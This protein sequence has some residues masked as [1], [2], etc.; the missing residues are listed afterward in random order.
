[1]DLSILLT[2]V[3]LL[4]FAYIVHLERQ[5]FSERK[6][7]YDRIMGVYVPYVNQKA[8]PKGK[9][10]IHKSVDPDFEQRLKQDGLYK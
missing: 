2:V 10:P 7:L 6:D 4:Q 8:A 1:M 3:I 5:T 9:S